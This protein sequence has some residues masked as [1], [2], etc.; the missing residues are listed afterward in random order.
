M[1]QFRAEHKDSTLIFLHIPKTAGSTLES[2]IGKLYL[3]NEIITFG[4][5][6]QTAQ[7]AISYFKNL[8]V[9]SRMRFKVLQ[10][11]M[12]FG[13]HRWVTQPFTYITFLR[14]P[15]DRVL[16][17]Y[18]FL[19]QLPDEIPEKREIKHMSLEEF[20]KYHPLGNNTQLRFLS[21]LNGDLSRL[22]DINPSD[23][24]FNE[25]MGNLEAYF[26]VVGITEYFDKSLLLVG[27][28][29]G[30]K[31]PYY[32]KVNVTKSRPLKS[33]ISGES[34]RHIVYHNE[35]DIRLYEY[36]KSRFLKQVGSEALHFKIRAKGLRCI[37]NLCGKAENIVVYRLGS[38]RKALGLR[39][40]ALR[41]LL[42]I[43]QS[44]FFK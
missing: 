15:V 36:W 19:M 11:H 8:P 33:Q 3:P 38:V 12:S 7:E 20:V 43:F 44:K 28:R 25:V 34:V 22:Q 14:D 41:R 24:L 42:Y 5:T 4:G 17:Q 13:I 32:R 40:A 29:F 21:D 2:I 18:Y 31:V 37:S 23:G 10:G 16:S 9:Q 35:Y 26:S 1:I 30:W 39:R 27:N 6:L